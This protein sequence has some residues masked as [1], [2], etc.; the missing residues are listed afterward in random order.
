MSTLDANTLSVTETASTKTRTSWTRWIGPCASFLC[1]IHCFGF[2][3]IAILAPGILKLLPHSEWIELSVLALSAS[4]GFI[5][6]RGI[7]TSTRLVRLFLG[8]AVLATIGLASDQHEIYHSALTVM[9][10]LQIT[11]IVRAHSTRKATPPCCD[12]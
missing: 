10:L 6:L 5:A 8:L 12:H 7:K 4:T 3:V 11:L 2:A 9:A 1:L